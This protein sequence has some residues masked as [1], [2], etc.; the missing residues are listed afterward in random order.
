MQIKIACNFLLGFE[1]RVMETLASD[2]LS[3]LIEFSSP[4][5][6]L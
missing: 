2:A 4:E 1:H 6:V 5:T 3:S